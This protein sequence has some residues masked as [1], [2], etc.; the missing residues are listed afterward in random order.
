MMQDHNRELLGTNLTDGI[1]MQ[2]CIKWLENLL[3][4]ENFMPVRR[5]MLLSEK[6]I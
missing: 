4:N 2:G 1:L 3:H 6:H 5:E